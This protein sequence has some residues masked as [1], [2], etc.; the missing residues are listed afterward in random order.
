VNSAQ[1]T[2]K[3]RPHYEHH[4]HE[5]LRAVENHANVKVLSCLMPEK[6]L[7][8][9]VPKPDPALG[10]DPVIHPDAW[11]DFCEGGKRWEL[12]PREDRATRPCFDGIC[13]DSGSS[14][15]VKLDHPHARPE[16]AGMREKICC[17]LAQEL[18]LPTP[19]ALLYKSSSG[20]PGVAVRRLE[21]ISFTLWKKR[22]EL[23]NDLDEAPIR[24]ARRN[25]PLPMV[26][27]DF[28]VGNCD[29]NTNNGNIVVEGPKLNPR[30]VPV[31]FGNTLGTSMMSWNNGEYAPEYVPAQ[32]W[33]HPAWVLIDSNARALIAAACGVIE[34]LSDQIIETA[35]NRAAEYYELTGSATA[36]DILNTLKLR[37]RT[38][39]SWV[40]KR[41]Q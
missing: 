6:R 22:R 1:L 21:A 8:D 35:V 32:C 16:F 18:E 15:V 4:G 13:L 11:K 40:I 7:T 20:T 3:A 39:R 5:W 26:A 9:V 14:A 38:A 12:N 30:V 17:D 25:Y 31:D 10:F 27:F 2:T 29:R 24:V 28:Y 36:T 41:L 34:A 23:A 19:G 33:P 37:R